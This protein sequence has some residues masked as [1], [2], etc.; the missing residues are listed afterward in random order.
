MSRITLAL[1]PALLEMWGKC[2]EPLATAAIMIG[3]WTVVIAF[4]WLASINPPLSLVVIAI[5]IV[6]YLVWEIFC[7]VR[8]HY[9][10]TP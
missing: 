5:A 7:V 4:G 1:R 2:K 9:R 6:L 10:N 8:K 3:M